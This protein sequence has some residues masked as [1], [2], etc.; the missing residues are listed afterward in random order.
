MLTKLVIGISL[1]V[2]VECWRRMSIEAHLRQIWQYI[3]Q[4]GRWRYWY[5]RQEK[6]SLFPMEKIVIVGRGPLARMAASTMDKIDRF[7]WKITKSHLQWWYSQGFE[8][9]GILPT[10]W[11]WNRPKLLIKRNHDHHF[12][13]IKATR[14]GNPS[15]NHMK[16]IEDKLPLLVEFLHRIVVDLPEGRKNRLSKKSAFLSQS[17]GFWKLKDWNCL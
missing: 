8:N 3:M 14:F 13:E 12:K 10:H 2:T 11:A 17:S 7:R 6:V 1:N 15:M 5:F 9:C 16:R 4:C